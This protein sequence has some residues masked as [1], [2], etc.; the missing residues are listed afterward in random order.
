VTKGTAALHEADG[1][2]QEVD[3]R[4]CSADVEPNCPSVYSNGMHSACEG[5]NGFFAESV[6]V[7][8]IAL[9]CTHDPPQVRDGWA[10][11]SAERM[12]GRSR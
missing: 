12:L 5:F 4:K 8:M 10:G 1:N 9:P 3:V 11:Q 6:H 7:P 2:D